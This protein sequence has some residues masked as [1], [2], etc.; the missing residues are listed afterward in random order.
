MFETGGKP[1]QA[2]LLAVVLAL[3]AVPAAAQ[4]GEAARYQIVPVSGGFVRLDTASG[5]MTFCRDEVD[6]F[7]CEPLAAERDKAEAGAPP[8]NQRAGRD[9]ATKE[10]DNSA[11]D[12]D[13]ALD[14]MEKAMRR[15]MAI[16]EENP[17]DCAL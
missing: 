4:P 3:V 1:M 13:R 6:K 5:A 12:F 14:M 8:Q 9:G 11:E 2:K 7:R 17:R 10:E 16:T 15:F